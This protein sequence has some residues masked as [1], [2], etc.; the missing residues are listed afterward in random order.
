MD[1]LIL[2]GATDSGTLGEHH[3]V[4]NKAMLLINDVPMIEYIIDA[5]NQ[6][7]HIHHIA[8]VGPRDELSPYIEKKVSKILDSTDSIIENIRVGIDY[9]NNERQIMT[10]TSDIPLITGDIIDRFIVQCQEYEAF[11]YYPYIL[12]ENILKKYPDTIRSYM[13][14]KEGTFCGGNVAIFSPM[15]FEKNK[16]LLHELY[17]NRKDVRKYA[18]LLGIKFIIKYLFKSLTIREIEDRACEIVGYPVKGIMV[19]DPEMMIDLDK[20]SDYEMILQILN[21]S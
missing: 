5:L 1:A 8:V 12:K 17:Q 4:N 6:A 13:V 21:A 10:L 11:F 19:A 3:K 20:M 7:Q 15:L 2:A 16:A 18:A 9:F 14:L